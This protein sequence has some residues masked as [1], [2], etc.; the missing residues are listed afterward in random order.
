MTDHEVAFPPCGGGVDVEVDGLVLVNVRVVVT[1]TSTEV[2]GLFQYRG[3][4]VGFSELVL[5]FLEHFFR[6]RALGLFRVIRGEGFCIV[7]YAVTATNVVGDFV[8]VI[9]L[10]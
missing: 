5:N 7:G 3:L 9:S 6:G 10:R 2:V 8:G 4:D 1:L